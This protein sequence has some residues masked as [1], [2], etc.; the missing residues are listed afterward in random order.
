M[1]MCVLTSIMCANKDSCCCRKKLQQQALSCRP[2]A[3]A[4]R[5]R[6]LVR[7]IQQGEKLLM[8]LPLVSNL[9]MMKRTY[10]RIMSFLM[11]VKWKIDPVL[12]PLLKAIAAY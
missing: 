6:L 2:R 1:C 4:S 12:W 3:R 5:S 11:I 8:V 9:T 10:Y 7:L